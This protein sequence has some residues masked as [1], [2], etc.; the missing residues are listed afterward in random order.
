M[1]TNYIP[2]IS[3]S[4]AGIAIYREMLPRLKFSCI[5][6]ED[7]NFPTPEQCYT[8]PRQNTPDGIMS[9]RAKK[10]INNAIKW[11]L[12][13]S[14]EKK[15]YSR[16]QK[17]WIKFRITFITL[18]LASD[19]R[20]PD[21]EIK[22]RLLNSM[23]TEMRRDFGMIH[24]VWRAEKQVNGNIHFH[25]LTNVFIPHSTLRK[26]WNRIQDKLGY[27]KAYSKEMQSCHSFG[28]YYN[29]YINQGSYSQLMRRYL[30]GKATNWHNP[31]STDIHSVKKVRNLPAYLSKYLCKASQDNYE[32]VEDIPT[33][34]L[35]NGKLWGLSTS[36]SKLKSIPAIITNAI[37]NELNDLFTLFP[38]NVHYDQYFTFLRIDFKS[39]IR[40]KCTNIMRLIYST[41]QKFNVNTLQ[42]CD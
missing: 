27:V 20:H 31:N 3:I 26:K 30:L 35:V 21:Q 33:E 14:R 32:K 1:E 28:D 13:M 11:L 8:P 16:D 15:Q 5:T 29:K 19:Q 25:I 4:P 34:L 7:G 24:Y 9:V 38:N 10:R 36:L 18:T 23:L 42:L 17:K 41:L 40:H 6:P 12:F 2:K 22:S 39:L 37:S